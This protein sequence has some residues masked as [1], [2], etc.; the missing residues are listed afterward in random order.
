ME[1]SKVSAKS[2]VAG[3]IFS[4]SYAEI[5]DE[6]LSVEIRAHSNFVFL[7]YSEIESYLKGI[8]LTL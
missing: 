3:T 8:L 4:K 1:N 2:S 7:L 5:D 6:T